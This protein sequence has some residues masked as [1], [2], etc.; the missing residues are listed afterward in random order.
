MKNIIRQPIAPINRGMVNMAAAPPSRDAEKLIPVTSP[1]SLT[2]I[3]EKLARAMPGKAPA[4]PTPKRNRK[5]TREIKLM[6]APVRAVK[7]TKS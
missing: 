7:V 5:T 4:S 2:G 3:H 6:A 1:R